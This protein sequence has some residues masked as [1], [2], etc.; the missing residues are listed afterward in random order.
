MNNTSRRRR[1]GTFLAPLAGAAMVGSMAVFMAA[2]WGA[3]GGIA[4]VHKL[5]E[6]A[7]VS[8]SAA[9]SLPTAIGTEPGSDTALFATRIGDKREW[10]HGL[11]PVLV[12]LPANSATPSRRADNLP[13][14]DVTIMMLEGFAAP[15]NWKEPRARPKRPNQATHQTG[16]RSFWVTCA[17]KQDK[18]TAQAAQTPCIIFES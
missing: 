4:D 1:Q 15:P 8:T 6:S 11:R 9:L 17:P 14:S 2:S 18:Q 10:S 5:G 12:R 7:T 13:M 16:N 3:L